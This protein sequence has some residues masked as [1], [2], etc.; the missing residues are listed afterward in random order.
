MKI[1]GKAREI[2]G[3]PMKIHGKARKIHGKAMKIHGKARKI[4][5]NTSGNPWSNHENLSLTSNVYGKWGGNLPTKWNIYGKNTSR[6]MENH[7][8]MGNLFTCE[9]K[10][11]PTADIF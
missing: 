3:K 5:G 7:T 11:H 9:K 4:Y 10:I 6:Y 1:H 2:H 8:S